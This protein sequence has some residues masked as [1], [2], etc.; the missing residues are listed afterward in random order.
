MWGED[1]AARVEAATSAS[2]ELEAVVNLVGGYEAGER[3]ELETG[4]VRIE[5]VQMRKELKEV[6][7]D[8]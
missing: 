8:E 1:S 4:G 2:D 7:S 5:F 3:V 6:M